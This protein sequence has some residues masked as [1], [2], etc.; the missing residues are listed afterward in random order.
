VETLCGDE[1]EA[2][3]KSARDDG[4]S[5]LDTEEK[6]TKLVK[7]GKNHGRGPGRKRQLSPV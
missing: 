6:M 1:N 4:R 3:E 2:K 5:N 7:K